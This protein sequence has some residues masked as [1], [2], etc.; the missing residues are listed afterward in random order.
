MKLLIVFLTL[1]SGTVA[2]AQDFQSRF[3]D[4][5]YKEDTTAQVELL[6]Q[7]TN[8]SP[9]DPE[10]AVA[11]Y[12]VYRSRKE[13]VSITDEPLSEE[14]LEMKDSSGHTYYMGSVIHY[15]ADTLQ[16]AFTYIDKGLAGN[17]DRLDMW[18]GKIYMLGKSESFEAFVKEILRMVEHSTKN[19]HAW[20]WTNGEP[21]E[22]AERAFFEAV[23]GYIG[24]LYERDDQIP[25]M[26]RVAEGV[27]AFYPNNIPN[28]SNAAISYIMTEDYDSA[29]GYLQKAEALDPK[30]CIVLNN[31]AETYS[32]KNDIAK[33][34]EYFN[35][36]ITWGGEEDRLYA[37]QKIEELSKK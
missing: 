11:Y 30:D 16:K 22:D 5:F 2:L 24:T 9:N 36:M 15:D 35:K 1:S 26:R 10:L 20:R 18:L 12:N 13:V 32:K 25:N 29:L 7:W 33:S 6:Q 28:L 4:L 17:P 21:K 3:A 19:K 27:L 37:Q 34:I 31:I 23:Q 14:S 8:A